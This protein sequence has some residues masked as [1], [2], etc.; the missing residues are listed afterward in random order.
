VFSVAV[1]LH[2]RPVIDFLYKKLSYRR[3][4]ARQLHTSFSA[5]SMIVH[6]TEYRTC[7]T[8]IQKGHTSQDISEMMLP[9]PTK[10]TWNDLE[11]PIQLKVRMSHGLLADS[12]DTS[13]ASL[14]YS[15]KTDAVLS[16]VHDQ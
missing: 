14:L 6:F 8:T 4:T 3:E 9:A 11:C 1:D 15:C 5:R 10:M 13:L 2:K 16:K 7:C 12:V